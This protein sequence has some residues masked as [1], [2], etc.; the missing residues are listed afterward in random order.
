VAYGIHPMGCISLRC[1]ARK[2][3]PGHQPRFRR[4]WKF[5]AARGKQAGLLDSGN[6]LCISERRLSGKLEVRTVPKTAPQLSPKQ[7]PSQT[8]FLRNRI[9]RSGRW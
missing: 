8:Q 9:L 5:G 6:A 7:P 4:K 3:T 2:P 1:C